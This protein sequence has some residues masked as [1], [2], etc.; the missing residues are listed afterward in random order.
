MHQKR[1]AA[2]HDISCFGK[3]SLTVA[4]PILSAANV[5]TPV[6]PTAVLSTHT[7]G[8]KGF[9]YCDLTNEIAPI[10]RHWKSLGLEFDAVYSGFLGSAEQIELVC[11]FL[12]A[13]DK[14]GCITLIDPAMADNGKMYTVFDMDFAQK[15]KTLCARADIIVP[16]ITEACFMLGIPYEEGP[17]SREFIEALLKG[18]HKKLGTEKI[19]LTGVYHDSQQL[20]AA[21]YDSSTDTIGY[22]L[23]EKI[24][25]MYHGTGDVFASALL[26]ALL[27][28]FSLLEASQIAVDFTLGC[29]RRTKAE[30]TDVRFGVNFEAGLPEYINRLGL[31]NKE[32]S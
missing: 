24:E 11:D 6:I 31:F 8:F 10:T 15:M 20:G 13:F 27:N 26:G 21:C 5:S 23:N 28:D 12:D 25:G 2:I 7:G 1:A 14:N 32:I 22:A 18:L 4:L 29:I 30:G 17:Y 9:T 19:V 16:N 3:C